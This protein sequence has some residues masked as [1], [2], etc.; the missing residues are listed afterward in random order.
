MSIMQAKKAKL[1]ST[2]V[3]ILGTMSFITQPSASQS[4]VLVSNEVQVSILKTEQDTHDLPVTLAQSQTVE[5]EEA[6]RVPM[7]HVVEQALP[8]FLRQAARR[9]GY[10]VTMTPRVRGTLKKI[11]LP[12]DLD[13]LLEKI[14]PQF[15]LKWHFQENQLYVS[16]GSENTT[17]LVFLG[18]TKML[19]LEKALTGAGLKS[20]NYN[21][22]YVEDSNSV[23]INGPVSYIASVEL[24]TESLSKNKQIQKD[25]LK[26]IRY[27]NVSKQ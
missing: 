5:A 10:Q 11:S 21:L 14:A 1:I 6:P 16:V 12:L 4:D 7:V 24:L 2:T 19:E 8:E 25:K 15:D 20:E 9:N 27:G 26:I 13:E 22:T 17:R 3:L 18:N 23:I